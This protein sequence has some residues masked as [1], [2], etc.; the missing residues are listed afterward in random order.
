MLPS[1]V[2]KVKWVPL[3]GGLPDAS[4]TCAVIVVTPLNASTVADDVSE[5]TEPDGAR[6]GTR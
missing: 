4:I 1:V 2:V 3:C 5:I 6:S